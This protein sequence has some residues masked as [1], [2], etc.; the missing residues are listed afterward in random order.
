MGGGTIPTRSYTSATRATMGMGPTKPPSSRSTSTS[1]RARETIRDWRLSLAPRGK[2][3][4]CQGPL[5]V[6]CL[7]CGSLRCGFLKCEVFCKPGTCQTAPTKVVPEPL[8]ECK[9]R[10]N[11][12]MQP[13]L[14][15]HAVG[16]HFVENITGIEEIPGSWWIRNSRKRRNN[17]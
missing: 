9:K 5:T 17:Y 2:R 12:I 16:R 15:L 6:T 8:P 10:K 1:V 7:G 13:S 14:N 4:S 11:L 3:C